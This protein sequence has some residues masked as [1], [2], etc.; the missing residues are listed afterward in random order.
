MF[1]LWLVTLALSS[2]GGLERAQPIE[3]SL[4]AVQAVAG[5]HAARKPGWR[6]G[7]GR[8]WVRHGRGFLHGRTDA[9]STAAGSPAPAPAKPPVDA[10]GGHPSAPVDNGVPDLPESPQV[11]QP[12]HPIEPTPE[13][14]VATAPPEEPTPEPPL[15]APAPTEPAPEPPTE[16]PPPT[17]PH[18][19]PTPDPSVYWGAWIDGDVYGRAA[20]APWDTTT[21]D[22]FEAD[23]GKRVSIV[24]FG[25]PA[26]WLQPFTSGPLAAVRSR[27]AMSLLD[28]DPDGATLSDIA[29]GAYDS[30]LSAW[31]RA[32]RE[33]GK[34]FF[35]RWS[36]EMNGTWF[37][38]GAEA[39]ADP[40]AYVAA[41]R[42]FHD[43]A[44]AQGATNVTWVWCPNTSFKGS[45]SLGSLYP[46][47]AYV[48]WTCIDGYNAGTGGG[49][50]AT[51]WRPFGQIFGGTYDELLALAPQKPV[52]I[53][54]TG[55]GESGGSKAEWIRDAF[56][57]LP[58]DFP[59]I[60][61][62]LWFNWNIVDSAGLH[63]WQIE[64]SP[65]AQ[66]AFATAISSPVYATDGYGNLPS[67]QPIAPLP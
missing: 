12:A 49:A 57:E 8:R 14:P 7:W 35:F 58:G 44:A 10:G 6:T 3:R 26:P 36:W 22:A 18:G 46:G 66:Q 61:A 4:G 56:S 41:W 2:G 51:D 15:E 59:R 33:Y 29:S 24:H 63:S 30:Q 25:Q 42:H 65:A 16:A 50:G 53:G 5:H 21:W 38:W 31:A 62:I 47:D 54:E 11:E 13:P 64:S 9:A 48:D 60:K 67:L 27:G 34:P 32:A 52:M 43:L 39:A 19:P 28:M 20:D 45:T 40:S 1:A 55:S 23:A 17:E 37:K